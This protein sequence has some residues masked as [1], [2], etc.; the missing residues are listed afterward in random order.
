MSIPLLIANVLTLLAFL[1]H[2]IQGDKEIRTIS[3][4]PKLD[5]EFKKQEKWSQ[6]RA[7]WHMVSFDLLFASVGLAVINFTE[8]LPNEKILLQIFAVYF[9]GYAIFWL[10][11]ILISKKF[12]GNFLKLGQWI[13]LL[14]ISSLIF[15]A[16]C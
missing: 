15:W 10:F 1:A 3:P 11:S 4:D 12:P 16:S 2:A 13:L 6:A 8:H 7:G 9:L 14:V 5:T